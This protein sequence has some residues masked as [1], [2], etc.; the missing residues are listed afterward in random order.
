MNVAEHTL[1]AT[2]LVDCAKRLTIRAAAPTPPPSSLLVDASEWRCEERKPVL[3]CPQEVPALKLTAGHICLEGLR[4]KRTVPD[5]WTTDHVPQPPAYEGSSFEPTLLVHSGDFRATDAPAALPL[6]TAALVLQDCTLAHNGTLPRNSYASGV[7]GCMAA[8]YGAFIRAERCG[9]NHCV[10]GVS[11]SGGGV[12][13]VMDTKF[14]DMGFAAV[15]TWGGR[16]LVNR[17]HFTA[18]A[19]GMYAT[20]T[21][22]LTCRPPKEAPKGASCTPLA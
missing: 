9:F 7:L 20:G 12:A 22:A 17:C 11:A 15:D 3:L 21:A 8:G 2:C 1:D 16:A 19:T 6:P 14:A 13:D 18:V 10:R 4:L 5:N